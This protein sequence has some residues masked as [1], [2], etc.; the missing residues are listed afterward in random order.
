MVAIEQ[1]NYIKSPASVVYNSL[2][3]EEGLSK[4]WTQKLKVKPEVGFVNEF[5]F[6]EGYITKVKVNE[7]KEDEK[8]VWE[9]VE[10]DP[11]WVGTIVSFE[12]YENEGI[13]TVVLKHSGWNKIT[14]F[15]RW[16]SYNWA[17]F[18]HRLKSYCE[19]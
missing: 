8:V 14:D 12:L 13:T 1:I 10:S 9:C 3:S 4:V 19:S 2:I 17:M 15:Y 6:D 18:L 5:D 11:E 7:L 16:C